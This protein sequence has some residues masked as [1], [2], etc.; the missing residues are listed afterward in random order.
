MWRAK[1]RLTADVDAHPLVPATT[2]WI[3]H[4][5][6]DYPWGEIDFSPAAEDGLA[7]TFE[8]QRHNSPAEDGEVAR[9]GNICVPTGHQSLGRSAYGPEPVGDAEARL[10]W[11]LRRGLEWIR[12]ASRGD[13]TRPGEP[14]EVPD[15]PHR[16]AQVVVYAEGAE[17]L[18]A[19][20]AVQ[21]R[22]GLATLRY[23]DD[24]KNRSVVTEFRNRAGPPLVKASFGSV[25]AA[26][27]AEA[28][29]AGWIRL[30]SAPVL[31][32]WQ[33]PATW[34]ELRRAVKA[35]HQDLDGLLRGIAHRLRDG[36]RHLLLV[37]Y[38]IPDVVGGTAKQMQWQALR[39]P[40]LSHGTR[41]KKGF[42]PDEMGYSLRDRMDVLR[43][44]EPLEWLTTENWH[45]DQI[46]TR[47][48]LPA[49]LRGL[50]VTVLGGGAL[51]SALGEIL[52]R[53]GVHHVLWVEPDRLAI[54]NLTRHTL[55]THELGQNK[56]AG[57]VRRLSA[58]SPHAEVSA[59]EERVQDLEDDH[60]AFGRDFIV[61]CTGSD[62]V[63]H[64]LTNLAPGTERLFASVSFGFG[65][66]RTY[67]FFS[68]GDQFPH[69]RFQEEIGPWLVKDVE[70]QGETPLPREGVGCWHPV[71]PARADDVWLAAAL[72]TKDLESWAGSGFLDR[73]LVV[74]EQDFGG[75]TF[76]GVRRLT[77]VQGE[78]A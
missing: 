66:R 40:I 78:A 71:F 12:D 34:G 27:L 19:W 68:R 63:L 46:A 1:F 37:G 64:R 6:A 31:P 67:S 39:M 62:A 45:P 30:H 26:G 38:P 33:A 50:K 7:A 11:H 36:K 13:L 57:L 5:A 72:V 75:G 47:G 15:L 56:G 10:V 58:A 28:P 14:F 74:Y 4:I 65:A 54:G 53:A 77:G 2:D 76:S 24:R 42:R 22:A 55:G 52:V 16:G 49:N 51:G 43:D 29:D 3:L 23:T 8:H 21:D 73:G 69:A 59:V 25:F 70:E 35:Q 17:E 61:D 9:G 48:R 44:D 32:P 41:V 60:E 20:A 18:R